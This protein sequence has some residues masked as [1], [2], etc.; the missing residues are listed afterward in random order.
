MGSVYT[1]LG[2]KVTVVE[3]L[4]QI[5]PSLDLEIAGM[6]NKV[7]TKQGMKIMVGHKVLSGKN[8][9]KGAEI[10]IE[11]VKGGEKITLKADH[12]LIGTGRRPYT[13]GLGL[14]EL[15]VT[16]SQ[17]GQ[18]EVNDHFQ[19]NIPS[20]YAIG[21]VIRGPMLAHKAEE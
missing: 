19:T 2:T 6:L 9:G 1:R 15:G 5:C 13:E 11:P 8:L 21:D 14:K 17:R 3:F 4:D 20:I 12:V 18:V 16:M 10:T 7:L